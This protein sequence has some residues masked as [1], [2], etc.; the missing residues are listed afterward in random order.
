MKK[1]SFEVVA[2]QYESKTTFDDIKLPTKYY[3]KN[4][5]HKHKKTPSII[6]FSCVVSW[7]AIGKTTLD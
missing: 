3:T 2:C 7:A 5:A 1:M 4:N 6:T